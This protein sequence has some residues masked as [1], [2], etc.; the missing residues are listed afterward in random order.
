MTAF[1]A[2]IDVAVIGAGAAG[3]GA[4]R[5]LV[6]AGGV[7]VLALEARDRVG[8]R[9]NTIA[10][11]GFALDRGAEWLHSADRNPLSPIAQRLGFSVHRRPPEW[12][13]RLSRSG[14]TPEAEA[15]WLATREQQ[16]RARRKAAS[17]PED[18]SLASVL[19]P[20]GRWNQLL[21]ATSTWGNGAELDRVSVKDYVRYDDNSTN[22][23]WRLREG[24]GRLFEKLAEGLPLALETAVSRIDHGGRAIRIETARGTV[25]AQLVI[26]TVPT[27]ILVSEALRFGPPLPEKVAAAAGLPLGVDDKLFIALDDACTDLNQDGFLVGSTTRRDTMSYQLRPLDRPAIYCFFRRALCRGDGARRGGGDVCVCRRRIGEH[28]R[29]RHPPSYRAARRDRLAAR[30]VVARL[31][32]LRLSGP[33]GRPRDPRRPGRR[34]AVFRRRSDLARLLLNRPRRLYERH[35]RRRRR[36]RHP[37]GTLRLNQ[38]R[39][40]VDRGDPD[41]TV[42]DAD[43]ADRSGGDLDP[44]VEIERHAEREQQRRADHVAMADDHHGPLGVSPAQVEEGVDRALLNP[45]PAFPARYRG[46]AAAALPWH[47]AFV[48]PDLVKGQTGPFA[49]I[50]LDHVF[51][52]NDRPLQPPGD[53][54]SGFPRAVERACIDRV[55]LFAGEALGDCG[56]LGAAF[57]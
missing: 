16:G 41:S 30:P 20:G 36:S 3:I 33:R 9:V 22:T 19:P 55:D 17:E 10:P 7:G 18:R 8:G 21:D 28:P 31:L 39:P 1:P 38:P 50:N 27:T 51:S 13:S 57:R 11:T 48:G 44:I 52:D 32:F 53:N 12:T 23:N 37:A 25:T 14:E 24:Y 40:L 26:V 43:R 15:D 49:E 34:P 47:P 45:A 35:H 42:I 56:G 4:T 29:Q 46:D 6:E 5:R 2:E 54:F